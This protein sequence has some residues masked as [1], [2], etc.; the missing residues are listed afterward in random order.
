[1]AVATYVGERNQNFPGVIITR[2]SKHPP[3]PSIMPT[4]EK[5]LDV[6][7]RQCDPSTYWSTMDGWMDGNGIFSRGGCGRPSAGLVVA[8][9]KNKNPAGA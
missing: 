4:G 5:D 7:P 3:A 6:T 9:Y 1:M 2:C 8:F